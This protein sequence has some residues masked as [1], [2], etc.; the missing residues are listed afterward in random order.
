MNIALAAYVVSVVVLAYV[1]FR[2]SWE[3]NKA[4]RLRAR[5]EY[6]QDIM[7]GDSNPDADF[8][9][10]HPSFSGRFISIEEMDSLGRSDWHDQ[11]TDYR[12]P[13]QQ[14]LKHG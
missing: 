11:V 10:R 3:N 14:S 7:D 2:W 5:L 12:P 4:L 9:R 1:L 8:M 6:D 13:D